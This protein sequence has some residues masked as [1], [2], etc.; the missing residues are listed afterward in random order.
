MATTG[1]YL[2]EAGQQ[3]LRQTREHLG[4][5]RDALA[6]EVGCHR[7]TIVQIE[8]GEKAPSEQMLDALCHALGLQWEPREVLLRAAASR[9]KQPS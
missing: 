9:N 7:N 3:R 4:M 2:G 8:R 1:L 6:A 5:T